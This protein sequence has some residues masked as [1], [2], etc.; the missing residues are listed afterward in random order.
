[1]GCYYLLHKECL[2]RECRLILVGLATIESSDV[3]HVF[4]SPCGA[5]LV[6][7]YPLCSSLLFLSRQGKEIS[8]VRV[9]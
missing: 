1:M 2:V 7:E 3:C 5:N 4:D 8:I 6:G 9:N